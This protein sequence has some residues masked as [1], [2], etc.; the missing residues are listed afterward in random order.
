MKIVIFATNLLTHGISEQ[1]D[2]FAVNVQKRMT[3]LNY[4]NETKMESWDK[5]VRENLHGSAYLK[6]WENLP[7]HL[8][9][10]IASSMAETF[11]Q[12]VV[13][14]ITEE[15][16]L[17]AK[18]IVETYESEQLNKHSAISCV[19]VPEWLSGKIVLMVKE[20]WDTPNINDSNPRI[21]A[22]QLIQREA[23]EHGY[24]ID[25]KKSMEVIRQHCL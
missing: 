2:L 22:V 7:F 8:K 24:I 1:I 3:L 4:K 15:D 19:V 5:N 6:T 14:N 18:K 16:Y 13:A 17:K 20:L 25:I 11:Q 9:C 12:P 23:K 21:K 10:L